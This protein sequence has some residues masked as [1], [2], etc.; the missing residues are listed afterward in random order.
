MKIEINVMNIYNIIYNVICQFF[1]SY[2]K[3]EMYIL[4]NVYIVFLI[5][6]CL[7]IVLFQN[8]RFICI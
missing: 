3:L 8:R 2:I 1:Y 5:L 6:C 7:D 4:V